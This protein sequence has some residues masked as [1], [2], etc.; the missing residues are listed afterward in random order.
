MADPVRLPNPGGDANNWGDLLNTFLLVSHN[1][2]GTIKASDAGLEQTA[3]KGQANGY[4]PLNSNSTIDDTYLPFKGRGDY[5]G[6]QAYSTVLPASSP[7]VFGIPFDYVTAQRNVSVIWDSTANQQLAQIQTDGVYAVSLTVYWGDNADSVSTVR[8]ASIWANCG[9][10]TTDQRG[11]LPGIDTIQSLSFTATLQV[12]EHI[13]VNLE[14][15]SAND[16]TPEVMLLVTK[17]AQLDPEV[18]I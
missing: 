1:S 17:V 18:V 13:Q 14:H 2:N 16:L 12:G 8:N 9:F 10:R 7:S 6:L 4:V 15:A 5:L 11:N 3:N